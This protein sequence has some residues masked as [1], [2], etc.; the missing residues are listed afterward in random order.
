MFVE[1]GRKGMRSGVI[2]GIAVIVSGFMM[3]GSAW[4]WGQ[5]LRR[6]VASTYL[7]VAVRSV[8]SQ[9][10]KTRGIA[11]RER[12]ISTYANLFDQKHS[13]IRE[14]PGCWKTL[15]KTYLLLAQVAIYQGKPADA[16]ALLEK[17]VSYHPYCANAYKMM[18][19]VRGI[20]GENRRARA[21]DDVYQGIM[22]AKPAADI[23]AMIG[24]CMGEK[25][26]I[27]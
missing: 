21:C 18:S 9:I 16:I 8:H 13:E 6:E 27:E 15:H 14:R 26:P 25:S 19:G 7:K 22:A 1:L 4:Y 24:L 2:Q 20:F 23:D 5:M 3:L 17:S 10:K 12:I 11:E